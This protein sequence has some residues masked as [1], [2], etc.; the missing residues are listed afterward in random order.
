MSLPVLSLPAVQASMETR[1]R[2]KDAARSTEIPPPARPETHSVKTTSVA[3]SVAPAPAANAP[4]PRPAGNEALAIVIL[5]TVKTSPLG[6]ALSAVVSSSS[7]GTSTLNPP[8]SPPVQLNT[9]F[10][11]ST[12]GRPETET[13]TWK[14]AAA[15]PSAE[16]TSEM[17]HAES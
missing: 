10:D 13:L 9:V 16:A 4:P 3:A 7:S 11:G 2:T 12:P 15:A 8:R 1:F 17:P 14:C 6:T 5:A